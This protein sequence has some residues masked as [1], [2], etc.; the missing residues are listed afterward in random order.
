MTVFSLIVVIRSEFFLPSRAIYLTL[1][2]A[3]RYMLTRIELLKYRHL[4]MIHTVDTE[5]NGRVELLRIRFEL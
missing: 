3:M 5:G 4:S 1:V 2:T